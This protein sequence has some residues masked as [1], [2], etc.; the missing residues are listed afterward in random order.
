MARFAVWVSLARHSLVH[1]WM[2]STNVCCVG[3]LL[4]HAA[5]G[6]LG[7]AT[8]IPAFTANTK[9]AAPANT[10]PQHASDTA[11]APCSTGQE[12]IFLGVLGSDADSLASTLN[13]IFEKDYIVKTQS[14]AANSGASETLN[15]AATSNLGS[16]GTTKYLCLAVRASS[17]DTTLR[18]RVKGK[19]VP[20]TCKGS[21]PT[22]RCDFDQTLAL[23]DQDN[24]KGVP[25]NSNFVIRLTSLSATVLANTLSHATPDL[26]LNHVPN[27]RSDKLLV[28]VPSALVLGQSAASMVLAKQAAGLKHDL[29][30]LD[31]QPRLLAA[32]SPVTTFR[33]VEAAERW[34]AK[35]TVL[36]FTLDP[37]DAVVGLGSSFPGWE[38][39]ARVG[40]HAIEILPARVQQSTDNLLVA[41]DA[42]ERDVLYRRSAKLM[43]EQQQSGGSKSGGAT[44]ASPTVTTKSTTTTKITPSSTK[45][46]STTIAVTE[47][48]AETAPS[49]G[50][51]G[52]QS[53]KGTNPMQSLDSNASQSGS[54]GGAGGNSDGSVSQGQSIGATSASLLKTWPATVPFP[55]D[56][57][58]RLYHFRHAQAIATAINKASGS[59]DVDLVEP[60]GDNDDLLLILPPISANGH[61]PFNDIRRA[62]ATID[63]PRPQLSLQVWSYQISSE[64]K[65]DQDR[66]NQVQR[67]FEKVRDRV[68]SAN[69]TMTLALQ[70]GLGALL[71]RVS[72]V[73][74][75]QFFD[76]VFAGYLTGRYQD[77]SNENHY[78]LGYY[79]ALEAPFSWAAGNRVVD[80]SLSRI[81]L[82]LIAASDHQAQTAVNPIIEA[83][84]GTAGL[85]GT[86]PNYPCS[87]ENIRKSAETGPQSLCF[88]TFREEL[89]TLTQKRSLRIWRAALLDFFFEHKQI[90]VY[91]NDFV[92]Y[93][94]QRTAH[95]VDS[96]F[97]P[98]VNA[99]NEDVDDFVKRTLE[100]QLCAQEKAE[101]N[102]CE[103]PASGLSASECKMK[104]N[105][106]EQCT[107]E[108]VKGLASNSLVQ[109][110]AISG[111]SAKVSGTVDNYFD[112]TPP[113]SL[114]DILNSNQ[115]ATSALK[116]VLEPKEIA[117]L[118]AVANIGSQER[119]QAQVSRNA[120][121]QITPTAL[122]T[123]SSA[124][125]E[126]SLDVGEPTNAP[127]GSV[128]SGK[129]QIDILNRVADNQVST[130]VRVESL[131]LFQISGFTMELSHPKR[132]AP[133][134]LI[135][136]AWEGL[137]G[138]MPGLDK[139]FHFPDTTKT[140]DNRSVAIIRATVVPTAMDLGESI[141]FEGDRV[142]DP[143][144]ESTDPIYSISQIGGKI[145][146]F[147]KELMRCIAGG[148]GDCWDENHGV[149]LSKM[150]EDLK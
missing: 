101:L 146:P 14:L 127:L 5:L 11:P 12:Q 137:F 85:S 71:D 3:K 113:M 110:T 20:T 125:L 112:I 87:T 88:P 135:G 2:R 7:L 139:L 145:R 132:G 31:E 68:L 122:D 150:P 42:I 47:T 62:I 100:A 104:R 111:T 25:L 4:R 126:V 116:G 128:N 147:H 79:R 130:T 129:A 136:Q 8:A 76:P 108:K 52:N 96:L 119:I 74:P 117:L 45:G 40:E 48:T 107:K 39:E 16:S 22:E 102:Q 103:D 114:S 49:S 64:V 35:H 99:F 115:N 69:N 51:S 84:Q 138:T 70:N 97:N 149:R 89:E 19:L 95:V 65:N 98:I 66:P 15:S 55:M 27:D 77:C 140:I 124:E 105:A 91:F 56:R 61:D 13:T 80:A 28:F 34:V 37:R 59:K 50:T 18:T 58:Q 86:D 81:L 44:P 60:L 41:A 63:L 67:S 78:C 83:M 92:P 141:G 144:T 90:Y 30:L 38:L 54:A 36:F 120:T 148:R 10:N 134:P 24:F 121:L 23:L 93:D 32:E 109:V 75:E 53:S 106:L 1:L 17:T 123:A 82:Y 73:S 9:P 143:L 94:L 33:N 133:L 43:A 131:K 26:D 118:S 46:P 21:V 72:A 6:V 142:L 57:V 29:D